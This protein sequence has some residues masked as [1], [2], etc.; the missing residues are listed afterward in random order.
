MSNV[1]VRKIQ[2]AFSDD[3]GTIMD[4]LNADEE[5]HHIG[6]ITFAEGAVRANHYHEHSRQ[7][8]YV[9]SG[10]IELRTKPAHDPDAQVRVD[11]LEEGDI[12][13]IPEHVIHAYRALAPSAII[14]MTTLSRSGAGYEED[15][16]RV[17]SLF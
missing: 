17:Q 14:D 16:I 3:R 15:T 11:I 9:L 13:S 7:H 5:I 12:V 6:L 2:P 1:E 8:D 10:K 4:L